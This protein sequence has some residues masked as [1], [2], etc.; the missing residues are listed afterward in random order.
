MEKA[1]YALANGLENPVCSNK[2]NRSNFDHFAFY[3]G[4]FTTLWFILWEAITKRVPM[5]FKRN[6]A[7]QYSKDHPNIWFGQLYGMS[8]HISFNL[9]QAGYQCQE[10]LPFGPV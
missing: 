1:A 5:P 4:S 7:A 2:R 10:Y 6:G 9:A 3:S 8:D